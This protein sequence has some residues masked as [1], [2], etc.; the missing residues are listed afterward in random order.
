M[1]S[2]VAH[3]AKFYEFLAWAEHNR[4]KLAYGIGVVALISLVVAFFIW[5][6]DKAEVEAGR[7]LSRVFVPQATAA[8]TGA[9]GHSRNPGAYLKVASEYPKSKA[10]AR[11]LLLAASD[12]YLDGKYSEAQA[13]FERFIREYRQ[14]PFVPE[15]MFGVA[16]SLEALGKMEEALTAYRNVVDR[17]PGQVVL[18]QAKFALARLY[19]AQG[20]LDLA[21]PLFEDVA[22]TEPYTSLGSEAGMRSEELKAKLPKPAAPLPEA[23][24]DSASSIPNPTLLL[25]NAAATAT[26]K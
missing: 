17:Y 11:A 21:Q 16:S 8:A 19:E 2:D 26:N 23:G 10:G 25:T 7:A 18:P 15:A 12:L 5:R 6:S 22:R 3:S 13:Q 1:E 24:S 20:K 4:S 9:Q 14:S